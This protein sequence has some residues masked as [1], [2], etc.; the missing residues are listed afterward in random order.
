MRTALLLLLALI[1]G[2]ST[3]CGPAA[4]NGM[5]EISFTIV[6]PHLFGTAGIERNH[7]VEAASGR[8]TLER[9]DI[10]R[11]TPIAADGS[12]DIAAVASGRYRATIESAQ[13]T[14]TTSVTIPAISS[15]RTSVGTLVCHAAS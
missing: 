10:Q 9:G 12:F 7:R 5:M 15:M 1:I 3:A 6:V 13:S 8:L 2:Y 14:C 11:S 4:A